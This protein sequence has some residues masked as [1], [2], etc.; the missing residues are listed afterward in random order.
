MTVAAFNIS[1]LNPVSAKA[2][3]IHLT[4][5]KMYVKT[6]RFDIGDGELMRSVELIPSV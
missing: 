2:L 6:K 3:D 1:V 5:T 4:S